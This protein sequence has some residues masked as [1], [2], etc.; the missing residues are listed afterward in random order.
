MFVGFT[1]PDNTT[2]YALSDAYTKYNWI[3][4]RWVTN[5]DTG[6]QILNVVGIEQNNSKGPMFVALAANAPGQVSSFPYMASCRI[7]FTD[8]THFK[9]LGFWTN[10]NYVAKVSNVWGI[11]PK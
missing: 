3:M 8:S 4:I 2:V 5:D 10:A 7:H 9:V 1:V 11:N 6:F